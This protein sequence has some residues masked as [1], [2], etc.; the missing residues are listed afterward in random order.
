VSE[1]N[2]NDQAGSEA[3]P[4]LAEREQAEKRWSKFLNNTLGVLGFPLGLTCL[5]TKTPSINA[6]LCL[7]FLLL[8]WFN[9]RRLM[10]KHFR[11]PSNRDFSARWRDNT[12][13]WFGTAPALMGYMYLF[14]VALSYSIS[15]SCSGSHDCHQAASWIS[16]YVG[17]P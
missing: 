1:I 5:S 17:S 11:E 3:N 10:P 2:Q 13:F 9:N 14:L 16:A 8:I 6:S 7:I 15:A 4:E 12:R